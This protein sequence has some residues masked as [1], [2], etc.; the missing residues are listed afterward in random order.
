MGG[1]GEIEEKLDAFVDQCF[2]KSGIVGDDGVMNRDACRL[3][4][5]QLMDDKGKTAAW[6]D[7]SFD[8][9]FDLFEEDDPKE[10][11]DAGKKCGLDR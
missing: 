3:L 10:M 7:K 4:F 8:E 6:S 5:K 9:T 2:Q 11:A 1:K